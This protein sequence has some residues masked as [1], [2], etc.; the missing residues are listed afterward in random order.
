MRDCYII[1][2]FPNDQLHNEGVP[3]PYSERLHLHHWEEFADALVEYKHVMEY[4]DDH[5]FTRTE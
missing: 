4:F 5:Q 1:A 2:L 3:L